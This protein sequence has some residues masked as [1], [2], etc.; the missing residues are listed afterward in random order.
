MQD[1]QKIKSQLVTEVKALRQRVARLE[2]S[3]SECKQAEEALQKDHKTSEMELGE[4]EKQLTTLLNAITSIAGLADKDGTILAANN[5]LAKSLGRKKEE[6]VG[7]SMFEFV[8]SET[9]EKRKA[10]LQKIV[11]SKKPLQWEDCRAGRYFKNSVY[12]ISD[13]NGNVKQVAWFAEETTE[14]KKIENKL[15]QRENYLSALNRAKEI[16]LSSESK[17]IYQEFVDILGP[18]SDSSRTY[19]FI[20]H[21]NEQGEALVSQKAEYCAEGIKFENDNR[22]LQNLKYADFFER[23]HRTLSQ[24]EMISGKIKEFPQGEKEFLEVQDIK[25]VLIIPIISEKEFLGFIGFDNCS[26]EREWDS[27]ER[28]FLLAAANDLAQ[29]I[30]RNKSQKQSEAENIRFQTAMDAMDAGVYVADMQTCELLFSNKNFNNLFGNKIGEK[31]YSALQQ[32]QTEPC[33]FCTNHLLLDKNGNPKKPYVWEFQN[34]ITKQ[35]YQLRD[36][37]IYWP[38]GRLVRIEIATDITDRK[39]VENA[40]RESEMRYQSIYALFRLM[41]DNMPDMLWAKDMDRRFLFANQALCDKLLLTH[42]TCEPVGKDAM[43]FINEARQTHPDN[44]EWHTFGEGCVNS[45][46]VV[47][48]N[49]KPQ[50]FEEFGNVQG[51]FLY[52]DVYKAPIWDLNGK[53]IGT[54]GCGRIVTQEK[55]IEKELRESEQC[56]RLLAENSMDIIYRQSLP[57]GRYEY[58]SPA[59]IELLGYSPAEIYKDRIHIRKIIHPD[60]SDWLEEQ[61]EKLKSGDMPSTYEYPI[62]HKSGKTRWLYQRNAL[63]SDDSGQPLAIEGVVTD[64][65]ER[66]R[67]EEAL[68]ARTRELALLN[69]AGRAFVSS[70]NPDQVFTTVLDQTRRIIG[71]T[72]CSLWLTD[73]KSG[74]LV[75]REATP[76]QNDIVRGW[77]LASGQGLAGWVVQHGKI[78]NIPDTRTD[79]RHFKEVD[80]RTGLQLRSVLSVPLLT[81]NKTFGALQL[82]DETE[83]RFDKNDERLA[84]SLAA[85]AAIAIKNARLHRQSQKDAETKTVLLQEVNHRVKNNLAAITGMLFIEQRHAATSPQRR[86]DAAIL[87]DIVN[88]IKGLSIV[89]DMLSGSDWSPQPLSKL[90]Q[91]LI[92]SAL[93]VMPSDRQ[94]SVDILAD[95]PVVVL[96]KEA[97]HLALVI[98]ELSTNVVKYVIPVKETAKI[99][100]RIN[101]DPDKKTVLFEFRD[102]GPGFPETVL[103]SGSRNVG[104]YLLENTVRHSLRGEITFDNDN[105]AV[106]TIQFSQERK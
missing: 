11:A 94:M 23:W 63:I 56:Y 81:Q 104:M 89:H 48:K 22:E 106:V 93:Q 83:N 46:E 74:D 62:I 10:N 31:C 79:K 20:N 58:I 15:L 78:L 105:G 71:I 101:S 68:Q 19:I 41:A 52:V 9:A 3:L 95:A 24:G 33:E 43:F 42:N 40:L 54:V 53:M 99:T 28:N 100:V 57:D 44:P 50:K 72:A 16:F 96:P 70:L 73:P 64:I 55:Q 85:L 4:S 49:H 27:A 75:C 59:S 35:W 103:N 47:M 92:N 17:D 86:T 34:T 32:G 98:N 102:N 65:T 30:E 14:R 21:T 18:A 13:D 90:T 76:L 69:D 5:A 1:E 82:L 39:R 7:H 2:S 37:A 91:Q 26:S 77:R 80:Q 88:R 61:W 66:K 29:F 87:N 12:P 97:H 60:W 51:K 45:D 8:S 67:V 25:A 36:Q 84:E 38:D 6:L